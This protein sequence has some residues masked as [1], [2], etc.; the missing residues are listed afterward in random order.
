[1]QVTDSIIVQG[2]GKRGTSELGYNSCCA[3][4]SPDRCLKCFCCVCVIFSVKSR[5]TYLL[6]VASL[7]I[8][9]FLLERTVIKIENFGGFQKIPKPECV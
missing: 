7:Y 9:S 2:T 4:F 3:S 5:V 6:S 1:M 8:Q